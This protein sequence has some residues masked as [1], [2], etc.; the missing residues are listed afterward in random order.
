MNFQAFRK[1]RAYKKINA[2]EENGSMGCEIASRQ[3]EGWLLLIVNN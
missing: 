2:S 3:G 1:N